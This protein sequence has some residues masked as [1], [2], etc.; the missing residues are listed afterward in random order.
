M[1]RIAQPNLRPLYLTVAQEGDQVWYVYDDS[2]PINAHVS[3]EVF[4]R[5]YGLPLLARSER[6]RILGSRENARLIVRLADQ[7]G[8]QEGAQAGG[9]VIQLVSPAVCASN[10]ER[11]SPEATLLKMTEAD[12]RGTGEYHTLCAREVWNYR[13]V[14]SL[15]AEQLGSRLAGPA[16]LERQKPGCWREGASGVS[17]QANGRAW[18]M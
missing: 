11:S 13:L 7:L 16:A 6:V 18:R 17:S 10:A 3:P 12:L 14:A 1:A 2:R 8:V 15:G 4:V 5:E 9:P